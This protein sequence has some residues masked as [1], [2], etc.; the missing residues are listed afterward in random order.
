MMEKKKE[1]QTCRGLDLVDQG[2]LA[3]IIA[4]IDLHDLV[5]R[6]LC[7]DMSQSRFPQA[8]RTAEQDDLNHENSD[9]SSSDRGRM[10]GWRWINGWMKRMRK[11]KEDW[12]NE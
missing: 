12:M 1:G 2:I 7:Q 4:R 10:S 9:I 6:M 11:E 3:A 5:T 8:W